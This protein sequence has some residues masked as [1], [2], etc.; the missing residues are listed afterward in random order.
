[1][2]DLIFHCIILVAPPAISGFKATS[3]WNSIIVE[4]DKP[5][6][7][8]I[9]RISNYILRI[10]YPGQTQPV[11][12]VVSKGRNTYFFIELEE[13]KT[14]KVGIFA[15]NNDQKGPINEITVHTTDL[16]KTFCCF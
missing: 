16:G 5:H 13:G 3:A 14:Y 12:K 6:D 4:W 9:P 7:T 11:D 2:S 8:E 1:L 10:Y 15:V